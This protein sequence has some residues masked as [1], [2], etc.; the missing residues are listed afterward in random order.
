MWAKVFRTSR[1]KIIPGI[2]SNAREREHPRVAA[3]LLLVYGKKKDMLL[4]NIY[5]C[6][7]RE[8]SSRATSTLT[9]RLEAGSKVL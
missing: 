1:S 5:E 7:G 4:F 9:G 8:R 6:A 3:G 2:S